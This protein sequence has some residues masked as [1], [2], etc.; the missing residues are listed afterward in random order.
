MTRS[1]ISN[2]ISII[3]IGLLL[4]KNLYKQRRFVKKELSPIINKSFSNNSK[5]LIAEDIIKIE[6]YYALFVP[7]VLGEAFCTLHGEKMT[8]NERWVST[9]QS[10]LSA[11]G[12][13]FF[14]KSELPDFD[15]KDIEQNFSSIKPKTNSEQLFI[16]LFKE[17]KQ[18]QPN[19][20]LFKCLGSVYKAQESSNLQKIQSTPLNHIEKITADKGGYSF[21]F[22]RWAFTHPL[23]NDEKE[24]IYKLGECLQWANDIFDIYED[25]K[26]GIRTVA[27]ECSN[28]ELLTKKFQTQIKEIV[29][30]AYKTNFEQKNIRKFLRII[31]LS[32][33]SRTMVCLKMLQKNQMLTQNIFDVSRY[34]REQLICDMEKPIN[35]YKGLWYYIRIL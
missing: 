23:V 25:Y 10:A 34:S 32:V 3:P 29:K 26:V 13:D 12:D 31:S 5:N 18:T 27:T 28:I 9:L 11:V 20:E 15:L 22:Y 35:I 8:N 24:L 16:N 7:A 6:N 30:L 2:I 14:D 1:V 4:V 21:L 33:F 17:L 19:K